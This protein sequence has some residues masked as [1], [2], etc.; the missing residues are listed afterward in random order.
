MSVPMYEK[1]KAIFN[2]LV[3]A[4]ALINDL[5]DCRRPFKYQESI[6]SLLKHLQTDFDL[7]QARKTMQDVLTPQA[8]KPSKVE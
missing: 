1:D 6:E 5:H 7:K 2:H 8:D 3:T 4:Q